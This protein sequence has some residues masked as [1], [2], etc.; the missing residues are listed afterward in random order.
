MA[1]Y[2]TFYQVGGVNGAWQPDG[3]LELT[4]KS[5]S[6]VVGTGG[7][8]TGTSVSWSGPQGN[9]S[10]TFFDN[11]RTFAGTAVFPNEGP[12]GYRGELA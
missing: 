9:A 3:Q 11:G 7:P 1:K 10:I 5:R 6:E 8:A 12:I 4:I 2:K